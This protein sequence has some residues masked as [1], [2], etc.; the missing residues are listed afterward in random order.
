MQTGATFFYSDSRKEEDNMRQ[1]KG[2]KKDKKGK[3]KNKQ[4]NGAKRDQV[5]CSQAVYNC[6]QNKNQIF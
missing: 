6:Y 2:E 4:N 3:K 1:R 5:T